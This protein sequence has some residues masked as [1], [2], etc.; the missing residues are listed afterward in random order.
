[1]KMTKTMKHN[2]GSEVTGKASA[3]VDSPNPDS[4]P[5]LLVAALDTPTRACSHR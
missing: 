5:W 3:K 4:I 2:D 1:M